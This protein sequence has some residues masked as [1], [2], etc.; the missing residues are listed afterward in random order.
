MKL[1]YIH[2]RVVVDAKK[3]IVAC[4]FLQIAYILST[5]TDWE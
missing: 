2:N 4:P 1:Y 5:V 3:N